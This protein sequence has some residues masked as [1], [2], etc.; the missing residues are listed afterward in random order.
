MV[1]LTSWDIYIYLEYQ[2]DVF[3]SGMLQSTIN[4]VPIYI[5]IYTSINHPI[6]QSI[7]IY[8]Y[9]IYVYIM[10]LKKFKEKNIRNSER[11][12]MISFIQPTLQQC[13]KTTG[14]CL[15]SPNEKVT[16]DGAQADFTELMQ[17]SSQEPQHMEFC[18]SHL[19]KGT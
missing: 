19:F 9:I 17:P 4:H 11:S 3:F 2:L 6:N 15:G 14:S 12:A 5:Y 7:Y 16:P 1:G 13:K 18:S 8:T 10:L